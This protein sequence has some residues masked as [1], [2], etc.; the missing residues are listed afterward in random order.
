MPDM[1]DIDRAKLCAELEAVA[2][3][4]YRG[5]RNGFYTVQVRNQSD[6]LV[7]M[8]RGRS[9]ITDQTIL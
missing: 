2:S 9:A 5:A 6:E 1:N 4:E 8:F 3:E 7:A